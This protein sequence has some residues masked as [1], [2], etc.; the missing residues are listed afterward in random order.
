MTFQRS[1]Q[2]WSTS[3]RAQH[4]QTFLINDTHYKK[5]AMRRRKRKTWCSWAICDSQVIQAR[6]FCWLYHWTTTTLLTA[7]CWQT[8]DLQE[9][10]TAGAAEATSLCHLQ[11]I[12]YPL[13]VS[14]QSYLTSDACFIVIS[15]LNINPVTWSQTFMKLY[16]VWN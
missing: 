3:Q 6:F 13:H 10:T 14:Y 9:E 11:S 16:R 7:G 2:A 4:A 8:P 15:N 5:H 1:R 12:L